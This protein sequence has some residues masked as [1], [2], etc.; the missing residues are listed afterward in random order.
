MLV[1]TIKTGF[2]LKWQIKMVPN[3]RNRFKFN[4]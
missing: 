1:D 2:L 3:N 4:D